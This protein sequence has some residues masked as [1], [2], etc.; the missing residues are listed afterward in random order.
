VL[1]PGRDELRTGSSI[2]LLAS[3]SEL[4]DKVVTLSPRGTQIVRGLV[5]GAA[6]CK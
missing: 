5:A 6:K 2:G 1:S 3:Q 4:D